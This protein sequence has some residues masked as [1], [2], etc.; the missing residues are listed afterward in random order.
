MRVTRLRAAA[1]TAM[2]ILTLST[3]E[4][5][6]AM[7]AVVDIGEKEQNLFLPNAAEEMAKY[8][9]KHGEYPKQW[10]LLG[11]DFSFT[12]YR[13]D[14]PEVYPKKE[15]GDRWR[16]RDCQYTYVIKEAGKEHF[17]IQALNK[18]DRAEWEIR[19]GQEKPKKVEDKATPKK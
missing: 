4:G 6:G 12:P 13:T 10:H 9:K 3:G 19:D 16:P 5:S 14:D 11:F 18:D 7:Q 15:Y 1:I 2:V 17:L 8:H